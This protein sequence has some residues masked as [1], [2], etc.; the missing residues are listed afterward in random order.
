MRPCRHC[1][2]AI[3]NQHT[4]CLA[5]GCDN[6]WP[7]PAIVVKEGDQSADQPL[8]HGEFVA[9]ALIVVSS[10]FILAIGIVLIISALG[11]I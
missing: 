7:P 1:G 11:L 10:W 2:A 8:R 6:S 5:C 3:E 9:E 4:A